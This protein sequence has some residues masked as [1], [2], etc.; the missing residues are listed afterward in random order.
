MCVGILLYNLI[1]NL[2]LKC[3][4]LTCMQCKESN[5]CVSTVFFLPWRRQFITGRTQA[6]GQPFQWRT[7]HRYCYGI[8]VGS[9]T[10]I[11][12]LV[13]CLVTGWLLWTLLS[14]LRKSRL[15]VPLFCLRFLVLTVASMKFRFVFWDVLPCNII[16][17]TR[18]RG[19]CCLHHR[20]DDEGS[21]YL[22]NVGRQLR[23]FYTAV[24][25]RRLFSLF[26]PYQLL[27]A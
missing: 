24:H 11:V 20:P 6:F 25:P 9:Q 10:Q 21:T 26:V 27:N 19:T 23:V 7:S 16:V 4:F 12:E 5:N 18:F 22:S 3:S 15:I 1:M 14:F 13:T 2:K 17:V 8:H